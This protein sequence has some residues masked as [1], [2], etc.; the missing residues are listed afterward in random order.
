M[1]WSRNKKINF[2]VH[3]LILRPVS[4]I[5]LVGGK[6]LLVTTSLSKFSGLV[7]TYLGKFS[8]VIGNCTSKKYFCVMVSVF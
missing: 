1:F 3:T 2:L 5:S 7:T 8:C 4:K 6:H